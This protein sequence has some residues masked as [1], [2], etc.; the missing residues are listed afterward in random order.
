M[1]LALCP[2][3]YVV[4]C[5][6]MTMHTRV[7]HMRLKAARGHCGASTRPPVAG[8]PAGQLT[9]CQRDTLPTHDNNTRARPSKGSVAVGGDG[10]R[11]HYRRARMRLHFN[12]KHTES[13]LFVCAHVLSAIRAVSLESQTHTH[14]TERLLVLVAVAAVIIITHTNTLRCVDEIRAAHTKARHWSAYA[15]SF[16][17]SAALVDRFRFRSLQPCVCVCIYI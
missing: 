15:R 11:S 6:M 8:W 9:G 13:S 5:R 17:S 3:C 12:R 1:L 10:N 4:V 14:S 2:A 16:G 7:W